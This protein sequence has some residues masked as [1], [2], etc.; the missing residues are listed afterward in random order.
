MPTG[1]GTADKWLPP[2]GTSDVNVAGL[3][4]VDWG[5]RLSLGLACAPAALL[6]LGGLLLPDSPASLAERGK[7]QQSRQVLEKIRGTDEVEAEMS[8]IAGG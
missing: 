3:R 7:P 1:T 8:D 6:T 4:H 5:W 2:L